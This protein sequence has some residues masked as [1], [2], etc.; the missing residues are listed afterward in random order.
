[1]N[2]PQ[3]VTLLKD[4]PILMNHKFKQGPITERLLLSIGAVRVP[5]HPDSLLLQLPVSLPEAVLGGSEMAQKIYNALQFN[6]IGYVEEENATPGLDVPSVW[7]VAAQVAGLQQGDCICPLLSAMLA[8]QYA[9]EALLVGLGCA[10][11][12]PEDVQKQEPASVPTVRQETG[13]DG[14]LPH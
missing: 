11:Y 8:S 13:P 6:R 3:D 14:R 5:D 9:L 1:M 4:G 7:S 2:Q 12:L 10:V